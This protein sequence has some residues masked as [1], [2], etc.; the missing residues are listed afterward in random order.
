MP[1]S[2]NFDFISEKI[3]NAE[4]IGDGD[5]I[6]DG[7]EHAA[8]SFANDN[9]GNE[10]VIVIFTNTKSTNSDEVKKLEQVTAQLRQNNI[11]V[12]IS[13]LTEE[14]TTD[15]DCLT[16]CPDMKFFTR[17]ITTEDSIKFYAPNEDVEP[18]FGASNCAANAELVCEANPNQTMECQCEG[19]ILPQTAVDLTAPAGVPGLDGPQGPQGPQGKFI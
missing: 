10:Q 3:Q 15:K 13:T 6:E 14:C 5:D 4:H 2:E 19:K 16:C 7:L 1:V 18:T 11:K 9:I 12:H 8:N 17:Y